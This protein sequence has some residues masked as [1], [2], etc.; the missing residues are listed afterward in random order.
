MVL[1]PFYLWPSFHLVHQSTRDLISTGWPIYLTYKIISP[2][3]HPQGDPYIWQNHLTHIPTRVNHVT[4]YPQYLTNSSD[5]C[6]WPNHLTQIST[7]DPPGTICQSLSSLFFQNFET[8]KGSICLFWM[9]NVSPAVGEG[10]GLARLFF[11]YIS[12][13]MTKGLLRSW[14]IGWVG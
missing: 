12:S 6:I 14:W 10:V 11:N 1:Q 3:I 4:R 13:W 8:R 2:D 9:S 5:P 7:S